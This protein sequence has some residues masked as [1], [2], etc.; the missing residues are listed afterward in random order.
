MIEPLFAVTARGFGPD[1]LEKWAIS[2]LTDRGWHVSSPHDWETP[3]ELCLRL[4]I[5]SAHLSRSLRK[6]C[7]P[8][9]YEIICGNMGRII[10]LKST[11]ELEHYLIAH[12]PQLS[13]NNSL[14]Q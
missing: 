14:T 7:C 4:G 1:A 2:F 5:S 6:A 11:N 13:Q 8:K 9:P 10:W 12:K 3:K